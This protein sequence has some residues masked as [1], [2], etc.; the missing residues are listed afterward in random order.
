MNL[1]HTLDLGQFPNTEWEQKFRSLIFDN[2]FVVFVVVGTDDKSKWLVQ[3]ADIFATG[4]AQGVQRKVVWSP[5]NVFLKTHL[6][7]L[8]VTSPNYKPVDFPRINGFTISPLKHEVK[9]LY[10]LDSNY[11]PLHVS[12]GYWWA[13]KPENLA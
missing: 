2:Q 4:A 6:E 9:Y 3:T 11:Q 5:D 7:A 10:N 1:K 8:L 12:L 13:S